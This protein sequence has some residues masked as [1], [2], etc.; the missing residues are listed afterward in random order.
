MKVEVIFAITTERVCINNIDA[1]Q[2]ITSSKKIIIT[3]VAN[4]PSFKSFDCVEK[5]TKKP[6]AHS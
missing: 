1:L 3:K 2:K 6:L 5:N 4:A